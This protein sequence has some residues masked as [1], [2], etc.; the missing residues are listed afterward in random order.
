[1]SSNKYLFLTLIFCVLFV[2]WSIYIIKDFNA[3][4]DECGLI[5]QYLFLNTIF[6]FV[7]ILQS[8]Y[9]FRYFQHFNKSCKSCLLFFNLFFNIVSIICG[10]FIFLFNSDQCLNTYINKYSDIWHLFLVTF[11]LKNIE[12]ISIISFAIAIACKKRPQPYEV[13]YNTDPYQHLYENNLI[14][15]S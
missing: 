2:T 15:I 8:L 6:Y 7:N 13:V 11:I 12:F 4:Y 1:M 14:Y 9:L 5:W 10:I 3:T